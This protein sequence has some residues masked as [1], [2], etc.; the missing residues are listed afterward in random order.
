MHRA[1]AVFLR[2]VDIVDQATGSFREFGGK[3]A[4]DA[5]ANGFVGHRFEQGG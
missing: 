1:I 2:M 4:V 3:N 5:Q